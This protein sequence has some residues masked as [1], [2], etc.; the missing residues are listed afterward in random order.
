LS[1]AGITGAS[2]SPV[3]WARQAP[4]GSRSAATSSAAPTGRD[5]FASDLASFFG[6]VQ[7]GDMSAAGQEL[8]ALQS[9]SPGL[10]TAASTP[11]SQSAIPTD[12]QSLIAAVQSGDASGAQQALT[13][14]QNDLAQRVQQQFVQRGGH[15]HHHHHNAAASSDSSS[16]TGNTDAASDAPATAGVAAQGATG[17]DTDGD[18]DSHYPARSA[19]PRPRAGP[20]SRPA[21]SRFRRA[22]RPTGPRTRP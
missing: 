21:R 9:D 16:A 3:S 8:T 6:A 13:T 15:H 1:I 20:P 2:A 18:G 19:L 14:L 4:G 22:E 7:S 17:V 5:Q 10:Y 12:F 11:S